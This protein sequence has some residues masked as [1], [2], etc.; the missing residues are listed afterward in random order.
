MKVFVYDIKKNTML[1]YNRNLSQ[2]MPFARYKVMSVK[3]FRGSSK[4]TIFWT[5][6]QAME[7]MSTLRLRW[8]HPI[9]IGYAFKRIKEGGHSNQSQHYAGVSFDTAQ[10]LSVS[11]RKELFKLAKKINMFKYV[12]PLSMTPTWLHVDCRYG[13]PACGAGYPSLKRTNKGVYV[14][15]L[16]DALITIGYRTERTGYFGNLTYQAVRNFQSNIGISVTGVVNCA[17]WQQ[18]TKRAIKK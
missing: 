5:T 13:K 7:A 11:K 8:K 16:Q 12:E 14:L 10:N 18:L 2:Q 4:S 17:T 3:E 9:K 6:K 15:V 1:T